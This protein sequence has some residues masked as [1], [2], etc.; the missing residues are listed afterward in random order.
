MMLD[1]TKLVCYS[2]DELG[3][4]D[5]AAVNLACAAGL[6]GAEKIDVP[7]CL[8][9]LDSW[10]RTV[11]RWTD[12]A[13]Q[14]YFLT[15]PGEF[16]N[17]AT[18]FRIVALVTALQ[19]HC[20][21]KYDPSKIGLG[22]E[23]PFDF[24]EQFIHGVIQGPGGTCATLPVVYAAVGR[25]LG[26]PIRLVATKRHLFC[27]WDDPQTGE[28]VNMEGAGDG[29]SVFP[30]DHYRNWPVPIKDAEEERMFGYLES[31]SP[32]QELAN[33]IG[34]RAFVLKDHHRYREAVETF[35][36][37]GELDPQHAMYASCVLTLLAQWKRHL[38]SQYP[39]C[40]PR[41]IEVLL[42]KDR[43][44]WQSMPWEVEREIASL[45]VTEFC[46]RHPPHVEMWWG[47]LRQ[48]RPPLRMVPGQFTADYEELLR[49]DR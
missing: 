14:E 29:F 28:R 23:A 31:W 7:F 15:N 24:D 49:I 44:R 2:D 34:H 22:P 41:R 3:K 45:H 11:K 26:Y 25:R 35:A 13:Y 36:A 43:R 32:R 9:A 38:Q 10:A 4:L 1:W 37:A 16:Q 6:P 20:G 17:S 47:P 19:R 33:F 18:F 12:A 46:L 5:I 27:R 21:V 8:R 30:D 39:P 48:G 42:R 40:F